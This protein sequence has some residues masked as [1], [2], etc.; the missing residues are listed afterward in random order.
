LNKL[1]LPAMIKASNGSVCSA[2]YALCLMLY[3]MN[4]PTKFTRLHTL[5]GRDYSQ[6]ARLFDE[7]ICFVYG[8]HKDKVRNVY[9]YYIMLN[10]D[11][12]YM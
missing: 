4:Y 12:V 3:K 10:T 9:M 11:C 6:L 2:E 1:A 8:M 5:F 7:T